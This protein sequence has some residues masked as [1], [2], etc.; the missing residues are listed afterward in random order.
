MP[1][2]RHAAAPLTLLA[3]ATLVA[4][5]GGIELKADSVPVPFSVD[6]TPSASAGVPAYVCTAAYKI[7]TDG[8]VRIAGLLSDAGGIRSALTDMAAELTAEA[9][10]TDA[11]D[12]ATALRAVAADL[13][14]GS[15]QADPEAYAEGGFATVG[16]K[17][18][19][20]CT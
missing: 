3:M 5:C 12:L 8:A 16:Q 13:T 9:D 19:R 18:D 6:P 4:G 14:A 1:Q 7:L 17:L 15:R 10:R 2:R 20:A 11:A